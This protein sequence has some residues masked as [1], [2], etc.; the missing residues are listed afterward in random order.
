MCY[1]DFDFA[2]DQNF[3][4]VTSQV[5]PEDGKRSHD[6]REVD[7]Q[8][9]KNASGCAIP[10][11]IECRGGGCASVYDEDEANHGAD[12]RTRYVSSCCTVFGGNGTDGLN[13]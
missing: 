12:D 2:S 10:A 5:R 3:I 7:L 13:G 4:D 8:N 1:F 9:R 11:R 6:C